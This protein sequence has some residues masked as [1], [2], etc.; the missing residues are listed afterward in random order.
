MK[1]ARYYSKDDIRLEDVPIPQIGAGELL[2]QM[3]ACGVCGSDVMTW[4]TDRK[5]PTVLGHEPAGVVVAVGPELT[6]FRPGD[7]VF[8]HHHVPCFTCHYCR[9]GAYTSCA[10]FRESHLDPGGFAE[11]VRVPAENVAKDVLLLPH[12]ISFEVATFIEPLGTVLRAVQRA[13]PRPGDRVAI[14][15][16]GLMGQ[17]FVQVVRQYGVV[18]VIASDLLDW[19][20]DLARQRGADW[21]INP[22]REDPV[23]RVREATEGRGADVV[24]ICTHSTQAMAQGLQ[25]VAHGGSVLLFAPTPPEVSIPISPY[26][27]QFREITL[28]GSYS[29][30]PYDTRLALDFL[31]AG[32]VEVGS[33]ITHRFGLQDVRRA[34]DLTREAQESLKVLIEF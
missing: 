8:V 32:R 21:V 13:S 18:A 31:A 28:T 12:N 24:F 25:M 14:V 30:S 3:K 7:R 10:T 23:A 15:G 1:V 11:Y 29:A 27:L 33:L 20:L 6:G 4:Y 19:R 34:L 26:E 2:V 9:R 22:Q 5:A 16:C 17:I